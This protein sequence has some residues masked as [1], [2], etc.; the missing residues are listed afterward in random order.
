MSG[1]QRESGLGIG[2]GNFYHAGPVIGFLRFIGLT[3]AAVWF[4]AAVFFTFV[5][6]PAFFSPEMK[7]LLPPPYNGAAAELMIA[8][9]F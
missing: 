7:H 6:G 5:G 2:A 3:N 4:G 8:R 9:V 1:P